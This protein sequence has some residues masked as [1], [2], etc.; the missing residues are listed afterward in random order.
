MSS[1]VMPGIMNKIAVCL[2]F[3]SVVFGNRKLLS[4]FLPILPPFFNKL[5][6]FL[7][8]EV[9]KCRDS[10]QRYEVK[11]Q[12][13]LLM[14]HQC[15]CYFWKPKKYGLNINWILS[16]SVAYSFDIKG[17]NIAEQFK[18]RALIHTSSS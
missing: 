2:I 10:R 11:Q 6:L 12:G 8:S 9:G 18:S 7:S 15:C 5:N 3:T 13:V 1:K 16:L 14:R 17:Y 4:C